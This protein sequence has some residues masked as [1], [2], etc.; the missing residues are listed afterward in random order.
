MGQTAQALQHGALARAVCAMNEGNG[1]KSFGRSGKARHGPGIAPFP[2]GQHGKS[3]F[4]CKAAPVA[5]GEFNEH[6]PVS[7]QGCRHAFACRWLHARTDKFVQAP[8]S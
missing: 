7:H 4:L 5:Q 3:R 2:G 6:G 1:K 8:F